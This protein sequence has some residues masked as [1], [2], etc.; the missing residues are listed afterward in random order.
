[1]NRDFIAKHWYASVY[2]KFE[3]Q[4]HDI[5]FLLKVLAEQTGNQSQSI[6]EVACG[7]G[8]I[9][10]S[11]AKENHTV[12]YYALCAVSLFGCGGI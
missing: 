7:G 4:T 1:M 12:L 6:L 3:N 5:D 8:R 10:V 2:E 11:L 9:C